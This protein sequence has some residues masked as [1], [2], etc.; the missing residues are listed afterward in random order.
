MTSDAKIGLLLGLVFIFIIAFI[1]NGLPKLRGETDS[2][3]L[4]TNMVRNNPPGLGA[5]ERRIDED[6]FE[7]PQLAE[8]RSIDEPRF[9]F[10]PPA[11]DA[12]VRYHTPLPDGTFDVKNIFESRIA[13][14]N[15]SEPIGPVLITGEERPVWPPATEKQFEPQ[16]TD[17]IKSVNPAKSGWPKSYV[18]ISGD[19]LGVIAKKF[20]GPEQ[21]NK[22]ANVTKI[23]EANRKL[24]KS[25]D[26]VYVGQKLVIP[27][28]PD[29]PKTQ[30]LLSGPSF[31]NVTSIG[32][33]RTFGTAAKEILGRFYVVKQGDSL[34]K[35]STE[36][37][38]GGSRY[39]EISTLNTD[40]LPS[41]DDLSIGMRLKMPAQ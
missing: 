19:N 5:T 10:D 3:E 21:G 23:F 30:S 37:L 1:I 31:E 8:E 15:E 35:I 17:P 41:E 12:G 18:V 25:P 36:Q 2:N 16:K 6:V 33:K 26:E 7:R 34:W 24:L 13:A 14:E 9:S 22:R 38:G 29:K 28:L 32:Q 4:T 40:I 11:D 27:A 20:Y 39:K